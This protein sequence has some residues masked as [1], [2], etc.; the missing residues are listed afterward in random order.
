MEMSK[1]LGKTFNLFSLLAYAAPTMALMV[2]MSIYTMVDGIFIAR[3]VSATALSAVNIFF[4]IYGLIIAIALMLGT[5]ANAIIAK[6]IGENNANEAKENFTFIVICGA[7]LGL[8]IMVFGLLLM[9]P[10]LLLLGAGATEELFE[11]TSTYARIILYTSP[12]MILQMLFQ[13]FFVTAGKPNLGLAITIAGGVANIVLDYIFIVL[14][15][16]G[17]AGAGIATA[18]GI[19]IPAVFGL[20]Y[21]FKNKKSGLHFVKPKVDANVFFNS[22][23]N[24]SSEMVSNLASS[25]VTFAFNLLMIKHLGVDGVAAVTIMLYVMFILSSLF[26]G[27]SAGVAPII[28]YNYGSQNTA[29]LKRIFNYSL[30]II[31][32]GSVTMYGVSTMFGAYFIQLMA[33]EESAV[34]HIAVDGMSIFSICYLFMGFNIFTSMLFTA[35]SNGKVSA[36]ISFLRTLVF[37]LTALLVLPATIGVTGIW[38]A[39]PLAEILSVFVCIFFLTANR[40]KYYLV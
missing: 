36:A 16:M 40:K 17:I 27:Y 20:I 34:Y 2:F 8:A 24:G 39:I 21:F 38:L 33:S 35:F 13:N 37:V 18:I 10:I 32:T 3:Y 12:F 30:L 11:F 6:K 15:Q 5:G 28:S 29:Q 7:V 14:L 4:P 25:I 1:Q 19:F 31:V 26:M 22:C 9:K 23:I